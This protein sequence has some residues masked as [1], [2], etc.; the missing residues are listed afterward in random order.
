MRILYVALT[1]AK[2]KLIITAT[3]NNIQKDEENKKQILNIYGA[4]QN[5]IN[6][7]LLKKYISYFDW[8]H[9][10]YLNGKLQKDLELF[11]HEKEEFCI[12][13]EI[14]EEKREFDFEQNI[15]FDDIKTNFEWIYKNRKFVDM[16][17]KITVSDIKALKAPNYEADKIGLEEVTAKFL[18]NKNE[19]TSAKKGTLLHLILQKIDFSKMYNM[20][21]LQRFLQELQLKNVLNEEEAKNVNLNAIL[22][23]LF[24]FIIF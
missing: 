7:I 18:Q 6:P 12:E 23:F 16:P 8:I 5:S 10:V 1:R 4:G 2:E 19:I 9:L 17:M 20:E 21:D 24:L 15:N 13:E 3:A 11:F 22:N 14:T